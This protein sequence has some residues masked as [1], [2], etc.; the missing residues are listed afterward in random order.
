M[1]RAIGFLGAALSAGTE[2]VKPFV[3]M[4][5]KQKMQEARDRLLH[6]QRLESQTLQN[7]FTA[8]ESAL[9]RD[10]T[11]RQNRLGAKDRIDA[12]NVQGD[13]S[14]RL[15]EGRF[16]QEE[17][18]EDIRSGNKLNELDYRNELEKD[19]ATHKAGLQ[20]KLAVLNILSGSAKAGETNWSVLLKT[21]QEQLKGNPQL[22]ENAQWQSFLQ[23]VIDE[24]P[25]TDPTYKS[26]VSIH[27]GTYSESYG[28]N[29]SGPGGPA[30]LGP[31]RPSYASQDVRSAYSNNPYLETNE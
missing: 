19:L 3:E 4:S 14:D 23:G 7:Q 10:F 11:N 26:F 13:I 5:M 20:E 30:N 15:Q 17:N 18:M 1:G 24:V 25:E 8:G 29:R 31:A 16:D 27:T 22:F 2:T 28:N 21:V 6:E 12:I 9:D